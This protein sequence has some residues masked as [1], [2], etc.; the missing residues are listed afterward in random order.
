MASDHPP[1]IMILLW[2]LR[3]LRLDG[4]SCLRDGKSRSFN[5]FERKEKISLVLSKKAED[6]CWDK[7]AMFYQILQVSTS[8]IHNIKVRTAIV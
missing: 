6:I 1:L 3:N 5:M 8:D 4:K 7:T 2:L